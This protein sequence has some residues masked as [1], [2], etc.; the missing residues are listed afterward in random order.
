MDRLATIAAFV[1]VAERGS[2]ADAA[3][4]LHRSPT[5][6]TRAIAELES[7]LGVR[8]L[9]RTTRAVGLTTAGLSFLAGAK[10][11]VADVDEIE[12]SAAGQ[13]SAPR[14]E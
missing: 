12:R 4:R 6:V 9:S 8:L 5:A 14:G 7:R 1:E 11:V 3:R 13:A 10:C 2:F